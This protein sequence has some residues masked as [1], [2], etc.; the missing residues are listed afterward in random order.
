MTKK[1]K[2]VL[3][4]LKNNYCAGAFVNTADIRNKTSLTEYDFDAVC[5]ELA[6]KGYLSGLQNNLSTSSYVFFTTYKSDS[7]FDELHNHRIDFFIK[8]IFLPIIIGVLSAL[9]TT[10][11]LTLIGL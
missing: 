8:S 5:V 3:R 6:N 11:L 9:A 1:E 2:I 4:F 7:F 10:A